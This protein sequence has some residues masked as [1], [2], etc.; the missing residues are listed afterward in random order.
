MKV[1][2]VF[3]CYN[4]TLILKKITTIPG[5]AGVLTGGGSAARGDESSKAELSDKCSRGTHFLQIKLF[6]STT[7]QNLFRTIRLSVAGSG[8]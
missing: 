6:L 8:N 2:A 7:F 5:L 3:L 4:I 1:D